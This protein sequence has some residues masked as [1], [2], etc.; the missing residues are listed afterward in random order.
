LCEGDSTLTLG[1]ALT[2]AGAPPI[3]FNEATFSMSTSTGATYAS[4]NSLAS[5][6]SVIY[7]ELDI[8][9]PAPEML[10]D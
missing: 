9:S 8:P 6:D 2:S 1:P 3:S 10:A 7:S 4:I 5:S